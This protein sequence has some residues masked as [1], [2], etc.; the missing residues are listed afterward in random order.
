M[1]ASTVPWSQYFLSFI[2]KFK[3]T[4]NNYSDIFYN[5][6]S[7]LLILSLAMFMLW[8]IN[9]CDGGS[10]SGND[11]NEIVCVRCICG[12][13][14]IDG[15]ICIGGEQSICGGHG[16]NDDVNN[17]DGVVGGA[18]ISDRQLSLPQHLKWVK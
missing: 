9:L 18:R 11:G 4:S 7:D 6:K 2:S 15:E 16:S 10:R 1:W 8:D 14:C 5:S 12:E 13:Q 3:Q 17:S